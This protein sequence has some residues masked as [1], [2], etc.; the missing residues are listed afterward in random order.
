MAPLTCVLNLIA[1]Y[2]IDI[3]AP[4]TL[5]QTSFPTGSVKPYTGRVGVKIYATIHS[6]FFHVRKTHVI[7]F[8]I[9]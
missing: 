3:H 8:I 4:V 5:D 6:T 1:Q 2:K 9:V 7:V